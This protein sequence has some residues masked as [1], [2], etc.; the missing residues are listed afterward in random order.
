MPDRSVAGSKPK[1]SGRFGLA[2]EIG[3]EARRALSAGAQAELGAPPEDILGGQGPFLRAQVVDL[4][5]RQAAVEGL[6]EIG[7]GAGRPDDVACPGAVGAG[8]A[9]R[10]LLRQEWLFCLQL[11]EE[12]LEIS[13]LHGAAR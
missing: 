8:E 11:G 4:G 10:G 13:I 1:S 12:L 6:A 5:R 9:A 2:V 3:G 7:H